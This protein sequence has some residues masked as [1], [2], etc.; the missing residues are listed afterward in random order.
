MNFSDTNKDCQPEENIFTQFHQLTK[1]PYLEERELG[2]G[3]IELWYKQENFTIEAVRRE[4]PVEQ[5]SIISMPNS[6]VG[7]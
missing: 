1:M 3:F 2:P 5:E 4:Q 6:K 7:E